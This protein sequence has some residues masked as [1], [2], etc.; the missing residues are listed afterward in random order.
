MHT[1]ADADAAFGRLHGAWA[2]RAGEDLPG[3]LTSLAQR[4]HAPACAALATALLEG[5]PPFPRDPAAAFVWALRGA[6]GGFAAA[7]ALA[8]DFYLHAEPEHGACVRDVAAAARWHVA[9]AEAGHAGAALAASDAFRMGRG[10][11]RDFRRAA[12]FLGLCTALDPAPPG[13][14]ALLGPSLATDLGEEVRAE[15][16]RAVATALAGLPR[17]DADLEGYWRACAASGRGAS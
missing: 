11:P 2:A 6:H 13:I 12:Y 10:V 1:D 8:G 3:A 9:A 4:G 16:D 15:V 5:R 14:T 7:R 17:R